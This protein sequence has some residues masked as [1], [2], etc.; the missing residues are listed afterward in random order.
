MNNKTKFL[1]AASMLTAALAGIQD[2]SAHMEPKKGD[3]MEKCYGVVKAG[4]N[5]CAS[6]ANKHSCATMAKADSDPNEWIKMPNGLCERLTGG[7][8]AEKDNG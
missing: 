8:T 7:S 5:D 6:K 2:A 1:T 4:K 3:G